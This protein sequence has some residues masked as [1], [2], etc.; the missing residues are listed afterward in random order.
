MTDRPP[1]ERAVD[2]ELEND[3]LQAELDA[4]ARDFFALKREYREAIA[5]LTTERD[6][7]RA[8]LAQRRDESVLIDHANRLIA[9]EREACAWLVE[10][11]G[12]EASG[13]IS[14]SEYAAAIRAR[15]TK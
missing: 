7:A 1:A 10:H 4:A 9:G 8:Q 2:L 6:A 11:L 15:G 13:P 3:R 12:R 5:T 14:A